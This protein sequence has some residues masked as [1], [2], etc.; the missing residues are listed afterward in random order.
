MKYVQL[1]SSGLRV[2]PIAVGCMSYGNPQGRYPWAILEEDALPI[3]DHCYQSGLN[4][5]DT[6]NA[7]S[8]HTLMA[9][10]RKFLERQ[11]KSTNGVETTLSLP[12][13]SGRLS[14]GD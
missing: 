14:V 6:A 1:G 13:R 11:S 9:S 4:F 5:F 3:L 7:Y 10:P 12:P 8:T 2:S